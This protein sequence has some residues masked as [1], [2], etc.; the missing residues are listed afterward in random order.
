MPALIL[1]A[2]LFL[3]VVPTTPSGAVSSQPA[4]GLRVLTLVDRSRVIRLPRGRAEPRTLLT[5]VRYPAQGQ[6]G[7][8]DVRDATPTAGEHPL[9][10]F[11]HGLDV[12]PGPYAR[13]LQSWARAGFVVAAPVFPLTNPHAP[14]GPDERDVASQPRDVSFVI[15]SLLALSEASGGPL[16]GLVDANEIAVAGHSDGAETALAVAYSRRYRDPRVR[17]AAVLSGAEMSGIGG[18]DFAD[19]KV[20]LLAAQGT[21]DGFNEPRYTRA[22]FKAAPAPKYLL[23]LLGAGHLPPYSSRQPYLGVVE[24]VTAAFFERYLTAD[25]AAWPPGSWPPGTWPPGAGAGGAAA[26]LV[27]DP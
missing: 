6:A 13:L 5:Y 21:K 20:P 27:S 16:S 10:V 26:K 23:W 19:R 15:S 12:T 18:Y 7:A 24:T 22:Y 3:G 17:A 4:I 9:I 1:A 25:V 11:A 8:T 2:C 14:G